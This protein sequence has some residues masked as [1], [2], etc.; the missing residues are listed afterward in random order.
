MFESS[1][2]RLDMRLGR[3]DPVA[4]F[5]REG[6]ARLPESLLAEQGVASGEPRP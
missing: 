1:K 2:E 5:L 3:A 6:E 4:A